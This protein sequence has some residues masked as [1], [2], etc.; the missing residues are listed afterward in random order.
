MVGE[1]RNSIRCWKLMRITMEG[2]LQSFMAPV[3]ITWRTPLLRADAFDPT[4]TSPIGPGIHALRY[5]Q[6]SVPDSIGEAVVECVVPPGTYIVASPWALRAE[7][8]LIVAIY[9]SPLANVLPQDLL[10]VKM[11]RRA[12]EWWR[13]HCHVYCDYPQEDGVR[14]YIDYCDGVLKWSHVAPGIK[15]TQ[16]RHR[17]TIDVETD[18]WSQHLYMNTDLVCWQIHYWSKHGETRR[19]EI[20]LSSSLCSSEASARARRALR[21]LSHIEP[22]EFT[23]CWRRYLEGIITG[24][25][26]P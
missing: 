4:D 6:G 5:G 12:Y 14:R 16:Q 1:T 19:R 13:P 11:V 20:D 9:F 24:T 26:E 17:V 25:F 2:Y 21:L 8:L 15:A 10:A 3:P 7:K 23:E 22:K 18:K